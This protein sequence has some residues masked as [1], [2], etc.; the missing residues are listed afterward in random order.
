MSFPGK[1]KYNIAVGACARTVKLERTASGNAARP[2]SDCAEA[3]GSETHKEEAMAHCAK[4]GVPLEEG[5]A[6]VCG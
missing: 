5:G 1:A 4:T 3:K 2:C 6:R